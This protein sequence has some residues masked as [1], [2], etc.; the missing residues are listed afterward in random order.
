MQ[1]K[2]K[3]KV[4]GIYFKIPFSGRVVELEEDIRYNHKNAMIK[5][6]IELEDAIAVYPGCVQ[7]DF[8]HMVLDAETL[9]LDGNKIVIIPTATLGLRK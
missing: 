1:L 7:R 8:I 3:S 2:L 9:E 4:N 5:V 6:K